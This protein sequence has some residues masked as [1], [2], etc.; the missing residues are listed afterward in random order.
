MSKA[1]LDLSQGDIVEFNIDYN[2]KGTGKVCGFASTPIYIAGRMVILGIISAE[3][4]DKEV[5]P[6]SHV[7]FPEI[8]L[9]KV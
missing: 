9:R 4:I 7:V 2:I 5:Y 6:Y 8:Q 3:G 1:N